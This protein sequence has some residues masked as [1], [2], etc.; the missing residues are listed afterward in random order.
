MFRFRRPAIALFAVATLLAGC[1]GDDGGD[2]TAADATAE[3]ASASD[4]SGGGATGAADGDTTDGDTAD[5]DTADGDAPESDGDAA[6]PADSD[7]GESAGAIPD[8]CT[9]VDAADVEALVP[10]A[11]PEA[12]TSMS[13]DALEYSQCEWESGDALLIVNVVEGPNRFEMHRDHLRGEAIDGLGDDALVAEGISS[14]TRGSTDGLTVSSLVDG[15]TLVVAL[16]LDRDTTQD[17]VVP[18]ATTAA[19]RLAG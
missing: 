6:G 15:N 8:A 16:K 11:T 10:G 17:D 2:D 19:E 14:E 9:L 5:G 18:L 13:L 7:G 3:D 12:E 4:E 1:G